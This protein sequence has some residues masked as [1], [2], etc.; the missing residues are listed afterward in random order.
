MM[1]EEALE[2]QNRKI[3]SGREENCRNGLEYRICLTS[4]FWVFQ[5]QDRSDSVIPFNFCIN[6]G[7]CLTEAAL[8]STAK[9]RPLLA[10]T[11][12]E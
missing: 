5:G 12:E 9:H 11:V 8:H 4:V 10:V 7:S 6:R 3:L 1:K 2:K